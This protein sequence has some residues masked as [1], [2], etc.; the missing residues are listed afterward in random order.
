[1]NKS[2]LLSSI[3]ILFT[4]TSCSKKLTYFSNNLY[5]DFNWSE[6]ELKKIQFYLSEDIKL[7]RAANS[8]SSTIED[9]KIKI[10]DN[11]KVDEIYIKKGTPGILVFSPKENRFAVSFDKDSKKYLMFGPNEKANGRYVLMAKDWKKSEGVIT[12]GK[13]KYYTS[14]KSAYAALMVDVK[15]ASRS[16]KRTDTAS[17]RK[18]RG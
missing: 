2:L 18:V 15:K 5:S 10:N 16:I 7:V 4:L 14:S 8:G 9:G 11:S 6:E 12:Y 1:M 3:V 13:E 17:G